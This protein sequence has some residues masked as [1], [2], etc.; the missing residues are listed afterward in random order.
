MQEMVHTLIREA[1]TS[2][3]LHADRKGD[4]AGAGA[5]RSLGALGVKC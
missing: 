1:G 5:E 2:F 4:G 3:K